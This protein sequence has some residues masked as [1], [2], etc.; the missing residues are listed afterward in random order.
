MENNGLYFSDFKFFVF[1]GFMKFRIL[2]VAYSFLFLSGLAM[3]QT[4]EPYIHDPSTIVKCDGKY[5]TF[6]TRGGG[7]VSK[8]G[9]VW[10]SGPVRP[11]GGVA[12]DVIHIGDRYYMSY[13]KGGGGLAG[14]HA[15]NVY[16]MWT[17]TLDPNS[18]DFGFKDETIVASSNGVEDCDAIDPAFLLDPTDGRL[19][20]T[21]GTYF[22]YIRIVELDPKTGKRVENNKAKNIAIDCE[23]TAM[24]YRDGWYYLLGTHGTCCD[25]SNSTYNIRVGRSKKVTGPYLDNIGRDMLKGGGKLVVAASGTFMG[26]GHFGLLDLGDGVEK[27]SCHYESD[28]AQGGRSVLGV[29]PLLWKDGWP[30]AGDNF[31][32][33]TY[34]IQSE[35]SGYSLELAVDF[36]RMTRGT[37]R[38]FGQRSDE[39]VKSVS[40][41]TLA[42]DSKDWPAGN[43][44]VRM[45]DFMVRPHQKWRI[46]PVEDVG[47]Y[48]GSPYFKITIDSTAHALAATAEAEVITVP[49]FT[50]APEQ[51]WRIDELTDG[52][53]RIM[54]KE[55]PNTNEHLALVA[56]GDCTP[57]LAKF[58]PKSD[59]S[60]WNFKTP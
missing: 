54:P 13:A 56:V 12:P 35:R 3:A 6:G 31:K 15:S 23:A 51:L 7:L 40:L 57:T 41:Q 33:G 42:E 22:G 43:I 24:M 4:G 1:G 52:T 53:Y 34:E 5:Y 30:V 47:G 37:M 49:K 45:G 27:F 9:W 18:P 59:N 60:R 25:G 28:L 36:V 21:Y 10:N 17:K 11:G 32:E 55:V 39:P 20:L 14:G 29:R 38:F 16:I 19:W 46:T 2:T 48:P 50:G 44:E 8:D 58:D 26:P